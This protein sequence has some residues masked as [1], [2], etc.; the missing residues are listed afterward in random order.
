M[1]H[2]R[3]K[4]L[5]GVGARFLII[6]AISTVIEIAA[7][8]LFTFGLD[9]DPV[10]A[11]I[12]ASLLALV[13]AYFGNREWTFRGRDRGRRWVEIALFLAVNAACTALGALLVWV[14]VEL[15]TAVL[16]HD[17]GVLAINLVNLISIVIV[18]FVRFVL[19][20]FVVF[21]DRSASATHP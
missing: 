5:A 12:V 7:F 1:E 10:G 13:N 6:G 16:A 17:P 21:R 9:W 15:T 18:V 3:S 20:H 8:N 19:Y 4:R 11:K 14:G 2:T